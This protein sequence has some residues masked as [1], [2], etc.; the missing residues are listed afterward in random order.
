MSKI[1]NEIANIPSEKFKFVSE[2]VIHDQKFDTKPVGYLKDAFRRFCK[3]KASVVAAIIIIIMILFA[4]FAPMFSQYKVS[5]ADIRMSKITPTSKLSLAL[6]WDFWD[7]HEQMDNTETIFQFYYG[8]NQETG[9]QAVKGGLDKSERYEVVTVNEKTGKER[10]VVRYD[11]RLNTYYRNGNIYMN[12]T[13]PRIYESIQ[14]YQDKTGNRVLYPVVSRRE[15]LTYILEELSP[16]SGAQYQTDDGYVWYKIDPASLKKVGTSY[17]PKAVLD[18]NGNF[19]NN[20]RP[21]SGINPNTDLPYDGYT[22]KLLMPDEVEAG[23]RLYDYAQQIDGGFQVRVNYYEYY[24]WYH[25]EWLKDDIK[26]PFYF[27]GT[28]GQ[29]QCILTCLSNGARFSFILAVFVS[30]INLTVGAIIGAIAGYFGGITD[31]TIER[32]MDILGGIPMMIVI[33]LVKEHLKE[34]GMPLDMLPLITVFL[35]FFATGWTGMASTTRMQFYRYKNQEYVLAA[36][37]LGANNRRIM[38]KHI[39]PNALGTLVT[40]SVLVIPGVIFSESSLSY[41]GIIDLS[42]SD[43]T[44]VGAMLANSRSYMTSYPHILSFPAV[45]VSMLMLSFNLFGNGLRDAFN[46]SLRGAED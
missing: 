19:I 31:I 18:E 22:S 23:T 10:I 27:F 29:G 7:G 46:P 35:A 4:I 33:V 5:D 40:S 12:I 39:F 16:G 44:S 17:Q 26:D 13:D 20:Y 43:L 9:Q 30:V 36:R 32:I 45:F 14:A 21:Y 42:T 11:F 38:F 28:N 41:L 1:S 37:T 34:A 6:G 3:N 2:G 25:Q 8:I 24:K 15:R